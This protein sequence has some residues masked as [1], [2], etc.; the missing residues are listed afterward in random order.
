MRFRF[1]QAQDVNFFPRGY[2]HSCQRRQPGV[3][4]RL[5][6]GGEILA[7]VVVAHRNH[8]QAR[9]QRPP[10]NGTGRHFGRLGTGRKDGMNMQ[11]R[12]IRSEHH[13]VPETPRLYSLPTSSKVCSSLT[14]SGTPS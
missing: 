7:G 8:L 3:L 14:K 5:V 6:Q 10:H 13:L 1:K 4:R 9:L 2:F 12:P 11:I